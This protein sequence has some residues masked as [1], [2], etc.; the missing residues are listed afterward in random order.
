MASTYIDA[1]CINRTALEIGKDFD[2]MLRNVIYSIKAMDPMI[3]TYL[4][5]RDIVIVIEKLSPPPIPPQ[6]TQLQQNVSEKLESV[7]I[8]SASIYMIIIPIAVIAIILLFI[9]MLWRKR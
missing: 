4:P 9:V 6:I 3:R 8:D 5:H 1:T 2:D 7:S